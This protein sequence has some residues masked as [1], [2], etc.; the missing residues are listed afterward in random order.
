MNTKHTPQEFA[1]DN[2]A[3]LADLLCIMYNLTE[4]EVS[5]ILEK[6]VLKWAVDIRSYAEN[7]G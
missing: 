7:H 3:A 2:I 4:R 1:D 5:E 6:S